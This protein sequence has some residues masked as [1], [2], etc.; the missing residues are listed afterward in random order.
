MN[1]DAE[2]IREFLTRFIRGRI[3]SDDHDI[4]ASG[5]VNSLFALQLVTFVEKKFEVR[6][7]TNDLDFDNFRTINAILTLIAR[8]RAVAS[9]N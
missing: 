9:G 8:K 4:F 7:E 6:V 1:D 3:V 2:A 5:F